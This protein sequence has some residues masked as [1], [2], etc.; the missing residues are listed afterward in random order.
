MQWNRR[1]SKIGTGSG[2]VVMYSPLPPRA[3]QN[4][5]GSLPSSTFT[6]LRPGDTKSA[7]ALPLA[8]SSTEASYNIQHLGEKKLF[9]YCPRISIHSQSR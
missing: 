6:C 1:G 4:S 2:W 9:K 5:S 3:F 7:M 8:F